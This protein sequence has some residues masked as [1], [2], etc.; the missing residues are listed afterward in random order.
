MSW[1]WGAYLGEEGLRPGIRAKISSWQRIGA[2]VIPHVAKATGVYLNSMLAVT[3]A[4][5]AGYDEAILLTA[6][7]Y[8]ADGSGENIFIVRDGEISTPTL[9]TSILPGITRDTVIQIAQDLGHVVEESIIRTDLYLADEVFMCGTAAE[10]TPIRVG[11]RPRVGVGPDHAR[12]PG[13]VPRH[14]ARPERALG[15]L[16]RRS[17]RRRRRREAETEPGSRSRGRTSTSARRSSCS[18]CCARA[19]S[20]SARRS[21]ASRSSSPSAVG[22]PYAAA[23][24]SGHRGPAPALP[25]AGVGPGDEV[26]TSPYSFAASANCFIYEGAEPVF[27]DV[28]PRTLQPRPGR[29]RGR[30]HAADEGDRR[31]GHL[32]LPVRARPAA[33]DVRAARPRARS[34]TRARRSAP[35]TAARRV[36]SH[37]ASAVFAFYPNKQITTGEGG[38][39]DDALRG[40]VAPAPLA[41]EPG[42]GRL[43]RLARP[44]AA[45]LQLPARRHPRRDRRRPG[46][47]ARRDPRAAR[48]A[49]ARY[50]ELLDGR[51]RA[52]T[53]PLADDGDH[54]RSWFV[55]VVE[56]A[57]GIDRER[58]IA[59]LERDGIRPP[60]PAVRSTCSRTCASS[61]ASPRGCAPSRRASRGGRSRSRSARGSAPAS[62]SGSR[63]PSNGRWRST[64]RPG[65]PGLGEALVAWLVVGLEAAATL[66]TY[67]RL[68]PEQLY[69]V[70]DAGDLVSGLGRTLVLLDYPIALAAAALA[71]VAGGPRL[72]VWGAIALCAVTAVPGVVDQDDLDAR[73]VNAIPAL[74]VGIAFALTL[75]AARREAWA[76]SAV[77]A[78][79]GSGSSSPSRSWSWRCPGWP[80]TWAPIS[81][82]T[83]SWARRSPPCATRA[84]RRSTSASTTGWAAWCSRSSRSCSRARR[85]GV[86]CARTSH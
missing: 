76:S 44:R 10:V 8:V 1:P 12:D 9:S 7:G 29:R 72:L 35:S 82:A 20:R 59:S 74:G 79:T 49:A 41:P 43:R 37:G 65:R 63:R 64:V 54:V 31:R 4:N 32:R 3:E 69:N 11:R 19:G 26:I 30:D 51:R 73:W 13:G 70:D 33:R 2:N 6:E 68:R 62:S 48:G 60:L 24:S 36:G 53:L 77:R 57:E 18:R 67:S 15:A 23:V 52:S 45:R 5:R 42:P 27:A 21:I 25:H 56:L 78:A 66:V 22:A 58:V 39:V 81:R 85:Q 28:D 38:M 47:E 61:T 83:S 55:Y 16:A 17:R 71:V 84:S 50:A 80:R 75:V 46:R 86:R 40:G 34:R 14:G